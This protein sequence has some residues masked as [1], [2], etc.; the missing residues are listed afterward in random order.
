[1]ELIGLLKI[2]DTKDLI[3]E[4]AE[5]L[6][7]EEAEKLAELKQQKKRAYDSGYREFEYGENIEELNELITGLYVTMRETEKAI[8]SFWKYTKEREREVSLYVLLR[9]IDRFGDDADWKLAYE[10]GLK[11][12]IKPRKLLQEIYHDLCEKGAEEKTE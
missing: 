7:R 6:L 12:K 5:L 1:M 2:P 8:R 4:Q 10:D 9:V 11:R 3:I